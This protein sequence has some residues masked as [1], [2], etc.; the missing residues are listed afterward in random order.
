MHNATASS[1]WAGCHDDLAGA[2][3]RRCPAERRLYST[4][5]RVC[6]SRAPYWEHIPPASFMW[7]LSSPVLTL[8]GM[9]GPAHRHLSSCLE[10]LYIALWLLF[11]SSVQLCTQSCK[12]QYAYWN[13]DLTDFGIFAGLG[14]FVTLWGS[15]LKA[16]KS[17]CSEAIEIERDSMCLLMGAVLSKKKTIET[18]GLKWKIDKVWTWH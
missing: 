10:E 1:G 4:L 3:E 7:F 18:F 2:R 14:S 15:H 16:L 17:S 6:N 12:V 13:L 5:Y 8:S 11:Y 9:L